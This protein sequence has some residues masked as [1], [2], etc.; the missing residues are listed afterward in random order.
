[1]IVHPKLRNVNPHN[2]T[3][4]LISQNPREWMFVVQIS[5]PYCH[6]YLPY[7]TNFV[8]NASHP[9]S[10]P[11]PSHRAMWQYVQCHVLLL[12]PLV[13]WWLHAYATSPIKAKWS[14]PHKQRW[15]ENEFKFHSV[16]CYTKSK[17]NHASMSTLQNSVI[18]RAL[19]LPQMWYYA[20]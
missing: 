8:I 2:T 15:E 11:T 7:I 3:H 17:V 18:S 10:Q 12:L 14:G 20:V 1:M 6:I 5:L 4:S 16:T 13:E 19:C 9:K